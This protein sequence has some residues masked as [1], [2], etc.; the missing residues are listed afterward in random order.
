MPTYMLG[1]DYMREFH[2]LLVSKFYSAI[3]SNGYP[4]YLQHHII[5]LQSFCCRG[6]GVN[7]EHQAA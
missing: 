2:P 4:L 6:Q 5:D 3:I 1:A 7:L